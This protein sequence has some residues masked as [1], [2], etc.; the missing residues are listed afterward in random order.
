MGVGER[1]LFSS[2]LLD[3]ARQARTTSVGFRGQREQMIAVGFDLVSW[4]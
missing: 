4:T 2:F 3:I 1:Q